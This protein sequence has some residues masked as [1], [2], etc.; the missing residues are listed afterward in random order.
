MF[1]QVLDKKD[2][3]YAVGQG[4]IAVECR[5][6]DDDVLTVLEPLMHRDSTLSVLAERS[7][8]RKLGGGC[9]TPIG[10]NSVVNKNSITLTASI[11]SLDGTDMITHTLESDLFDK[12]LIRNHINFYRDESGE[13]PK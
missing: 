11:F 6:D 13:P 7:F 5:E 12:S 2:M 10:V 4:A 1:A 9:S 8:L 3:L